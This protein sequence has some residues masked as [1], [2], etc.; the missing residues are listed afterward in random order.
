M[1]VVVVI[2][3]VI[4]AIL[5]RDARERPL[6]SPDQDEPFRRA[7][8]ELGLTLVYPARL[9]QGDTGTF[10]VQVVNRSATPMPAVKV[11]MVFS[12]TR[13]VSLPITGSN[14]L[15]LGALAPDET[16]HREFSLRLVRHVPTTFSLRVAPG[17]GRE[18]QSTP[19]TV[20]VGIIPY[21]NR[22]LSSVIGWLIGTALVSTVVALIQRAIKGD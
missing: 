18:A 4:G 10:E 2:V 22:L 14:V 7:L 19:R 3:A 17:D 16:K 20:D 13:F 5:W 6:V 1:L 21:L 11:A 8:P 12:D 15:D 9:Y